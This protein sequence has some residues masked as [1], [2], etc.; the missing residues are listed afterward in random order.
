MLRVRGAKEKRFEGV[1][2]E[3]TAKYVGITRWGEH[4]SANHKRWKYASSIYPPGM[5]TYCLQ[6]TKLI[7]HGNNYQN[8]AFDLL[9]NKWSNF[10]LP[11]SLTLS[12]FFSKTKH[13]Q[14]QRRLN[15]SILSEKFKPRDG[16]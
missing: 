12:H 9:Q 11:S 8:L 14:F 4:I 13:V 16:W 7:S 1:L 3:Q 2:T 15:L 10:K 6:Q 5:E